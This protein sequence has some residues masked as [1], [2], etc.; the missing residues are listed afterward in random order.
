MEL[1]DSFL[2]LLQCFDSV[3]TAPTFQSLLVIVTGWIL[4][5]RRRYV[6]ELSF[7]SGP[8]GKGHWSRFHRFFSHAAWNIDSFSLCLAK[9]V[10]TILAPGAT[11]TWAVDDTLCRK[12]GLTL[13]GAGMHY[14]PLISSRAKSLVRRMAVFWAK[15]I[16]VV[17]QHWLLLMSSWSEPRRSLAKAAQ[18]IREWIPSLTQALRNGDGLIEVLANMTAA[19]DA[20]AK[21]E[22]RRKDPSSFQLLFNPEL[23]DWDS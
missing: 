23:L 13:H 2:T 4:S 11:F 10:V 12:R 16:G 8:V 17:L 15:L 5:Q 1:G 21:Q 22:L 9:L 7:S 19:I 6:T 20:V 3:F 14:D 18:V